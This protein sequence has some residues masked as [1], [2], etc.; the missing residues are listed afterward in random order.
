M[1]VLGKSLLDHWN[2]QHLSFEANK[3]KNCTKVDS[4][5]QLTSK[6]WRSQHFRRYSPQIEIHN[7]KFMPKLLDSLNYVG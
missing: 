3:K 4:E 1:V 5:L 6:R 2:E 7:C